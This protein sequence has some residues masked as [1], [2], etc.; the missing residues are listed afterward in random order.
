MSARRLYLL[1]VEGTVAPIAFV[2]ERLFPYA[3][4]RFGAY[5]NKSWSDAAVQ[6]DLARLVQ[7]NRTE[8]DVDAPRFELSS[9]IEVSREKTLSYLLW[10]MDRDRKSTALKSLQGKLWKIG[11]EAG[12]LQGELF[13]DV[14]EALTRWS[15]SGCVAIY[16]SG[17]VEAQ[18][19]LFRYSSYGDL[20]PYISSYFDTRAG[21]KTAI[22]SYRAIVEAMGVIP[23]GAIFF[24]DVLRE[25]DPAREA[26][27]G[28]RLV[29]RPGNA[30]V[31][32]GHG[33]VAIDSFAGA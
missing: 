9:E 32:E 17:S 8:T 6:E 7:E 24:S 13:A 1:D 16:S 26:G 28:T 11:F 30:A 29:M 21:A 31:E 22:A 10:L 15:K 3:R 20:T 12:E 33:H 18:K 23:E 5:L 4:E 14:P 19:L 25:L 2:Y 27:L